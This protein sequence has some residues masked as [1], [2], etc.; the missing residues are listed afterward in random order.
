VVANPEVE[1]PRTC[2]EVGLHGTHHQQ[3]EGATG[4]IWT[5][6]GWL[7]TNLPLLISCC[8]PASMSFGLM[9][10]QIPPQNSDLLFGV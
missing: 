3:N 2:G 1:P 8:R 5:L 9:L 4:D 7:A 6:G 10:Q